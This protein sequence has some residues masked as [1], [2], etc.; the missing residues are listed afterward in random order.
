MYMY[1]NCYR[2]NNAKLD[3]EHLKWI[4][5][6]WTISYKVSMDIFWLSMFWF[7]SHNLRANNAWLSDPQF[8]HVFLQYR[9]IS[10]VVWFFCKMECIVLC[11]RTHPITWLGNFSGKNLKL[12]LVYTDWMKACVRYFFVKFLFFTKW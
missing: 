3:K 7:G 10:K 1:I 9:I 4:I 6:C 5:F 12:F 2:E 8:C 11:F